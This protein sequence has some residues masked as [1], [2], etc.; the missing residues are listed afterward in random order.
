MSQVW[1]IGWIGKHNATRT[2]TGILDLIARNKGVAVLGYNLLDSGSVKYLKLKH[3]TITDRHWDRPTKLITSQR[4]PVARVG[5]SKLRMQWE[6][7]LFL[8]VNDTWWYYCMTWMAQWCG[9][10]VCACLLSLWF[11]DISCPLFL[12][13][14]SSSCFVVRF[15]VCACA[16]LRFLIPYTCFHFGTSCIL[17]DESLMDECRSV[18]PHFSSSYFWECSIDGS[19]KH[20][21]ELECL[22]F[23]WMPCFVIW[24]RILGQK[25]VMYIYVSV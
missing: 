22:L 10:C 17:R 18:S 19:E 14:F 2:R 21:T 16:R 20:E 6:A 1:H 9:I 4:R 7:C 25:S 13:F 23:S 8:F 11:L 3:K 12:F 24:C 5:S 15:R